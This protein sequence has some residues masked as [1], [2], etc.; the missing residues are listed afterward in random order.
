M[1]KILFLYGTPILL[2]ALALTLSVVVAKDYQ[3]HR[4]M[5]QTVECQQFRDVVIP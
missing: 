3:R 4:I 2:S 1:T 5:Y